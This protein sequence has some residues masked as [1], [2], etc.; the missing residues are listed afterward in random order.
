MQRNQDKAKA[1]YD[2]V[3]NPK[4]P[5]QDN[6]NVDEEEVWPVAS[7]N[8]LFGLPKEL[9]LTLWGSTTRWT[10][11]SFK[12]KGDELTRSSGKSSRFDDAC[13]S[14][15][16]MDVDQHPQSNV[17]KQA[18]EIGTQTAEGA[19]TSPTQ[20]QLVPSGIPA[21]DVVSESGSPVHAPG[22][23]EFGL[24]IG[25]WEDQILDIPERDLQNAI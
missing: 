5:A 20:Q 8:E 10:L 21:D 23:N 2:R 11:S 17:N 16:G 24:P 13:S 14:G 1:R 19:P 22:R 4:A 3:V 6:I 15:N 18:P 12:R 25:N 9:D 7:N